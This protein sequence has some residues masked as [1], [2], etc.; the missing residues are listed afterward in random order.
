MVTQ[1]AHAKKG[2]SVGQAVGLG[3]VVWLASLGAVQGIS[4]AAW[5]IGATTGVVTGGLGGVIGLGLMAPVLGK[6]ANIVMGAMGL[7]MMG[8]MVLVGVGLVITLKVQQAEPFGFVL[9]F[10]P[11]FFVFLILELLVAARHVPAPATP[12][13]KES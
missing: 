8:R 9:A 6:S 7:G 10:F 11:L 5:R 3:L 1:A 2:F 12:E 13:A 4:D